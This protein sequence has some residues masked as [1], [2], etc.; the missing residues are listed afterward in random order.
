MES[1]LPHPWRAGRR[2]SAGPALRARN[3]PLPG[4][5]VRRARA[6]AQGWRYSC[7]RKASGIFLW[8]YRP[9]GGDYSQEERVEQTRRR[10]V[11]A[12]LRRLR[13]AAGVRRQ[14]APDMR[15]CPQPT[16]VGLP[17]DGRGS[18]RAGF[19]VYGAVSVSSC[20]AVLRT[21]FTRA[22][23]TPVACAMSRGEACRRSGPT[24]VFRQYWASPSRP[25][26][27]G[28]PRSV[29]R[30]SGQS[31]AVGVPRAPQGIR[32]QQRRSRLPA[33]RFGRAAVGSCPQA[34]FRVR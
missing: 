14:R 19:P 21:A 29:K 23:V 26:P 22:M 25:C 32:V 5:G 16:T 8:N 15:L 11:G 7:T 24:A 17:C 9:V 34:P 18:R 31:E 6:A 20:G 2:P 33:S 3:C 4:K 13:H 27:T 10:A 12:D 30:I 1:P 28:C